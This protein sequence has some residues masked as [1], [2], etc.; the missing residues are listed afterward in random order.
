M[1][2]AFQS[3]K[4]GFG[5]KLTCEDLL[6]INSF[7]QSHRPCYLEVEYAIKVNGEARKK[8]YVSHNLLNTLN[9]GMAQGRRDT[10]HVTTWQSSSKT[11]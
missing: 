3:H 11:V 10:G 9:M 2:S 4:L 6:I 7:H 8:N 5:L 1:V